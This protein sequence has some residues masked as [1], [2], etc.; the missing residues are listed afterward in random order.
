MHSG[1]FLSV[2]GWRFDSTLRT[3]LGWWHTSAFL[4]CTRKPG[5]E[6]IFNVSSHSCRDSD[7]AYGPAPVLFCLL[8]VI[9]KEE[10]LQESKTNFASDVLCKFIVYIGTLLGQCWLNL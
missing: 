5:A 3:A 7:A 8:A 1:G 9:G 10:P 2:G 6:S 4:S